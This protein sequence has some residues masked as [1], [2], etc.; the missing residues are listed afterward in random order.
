[1]LNQTAMTK[2]GQRNMLNK[3]PYRPIN[4]K[5]KAK[6]EAFKTEEGSFRS[7]VATVLH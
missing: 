2:T 3:K 6:K 5:A 7:Y 4:L 1:M